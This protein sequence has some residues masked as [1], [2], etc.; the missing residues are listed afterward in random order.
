M[1]PRNRK[2]LKKLERIFDAKIVLKNSVMKNSIKYVD[3]VC[4]RNNIPIFYGEMIYSEDRKVLIGRLKKRGLKEMPDKIICETLKEWE[5][6][7][8]NLK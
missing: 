6:Q 2:G 5:R 7:S 4:Y 1:Q 3:V 8:T